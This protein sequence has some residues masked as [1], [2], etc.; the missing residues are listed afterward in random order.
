[1]VSS[2]ETNTALSSES[3][4]TSLFKIYP[5]RKNKYYL[6]RDKIKHLSVCEATKEQYIVADKTCLSS[7]F[8]SSARYEIVFVSWVSKSP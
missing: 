2:K 5:L 6:Y 4:G 7:D 3:V 8:C 1:M